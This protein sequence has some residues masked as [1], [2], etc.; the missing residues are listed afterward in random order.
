MKN[1]HQIVENIKSKMS[2]HLA[3]GENNKHNVTRELLGTLAFTESTR[4][5]K[6]IK[7]LCLDRR[8]NVYLSNLTMSSS[9]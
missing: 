7:C 1:N 4:N 2:T 3:Q 6:I 5:K 9:Y 8:Q